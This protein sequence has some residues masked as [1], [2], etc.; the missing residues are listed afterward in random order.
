MDVYN[1]YQAFIAV[2]IF[3][4]GTC[5]FSFLNVVIYRVPEKWIL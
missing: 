5:I 4:L 2:L 3:F 1:S